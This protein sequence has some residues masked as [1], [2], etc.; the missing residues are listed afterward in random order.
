MSR[1][2]S[3]WTNVFPFV[4]FRCS[5]AANSHFV[6]TVQIIHI[7][8]PTENK[9]NRNENEKNGNNSAEKTANERLNNMVYVKRMAP[10]NDEI[11]REKRRHII[12]YLILLSCVVIVAFRDPK[13]YAF[14]L[15]RSNF[16]LSLFFSV[17]R[18]F[19]LHVGIKSLSENG[20]KRTQLHL[21]FYIKCGWSYSDW[22]SLIE[23]YNQLAMESSRWKF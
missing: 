19:A 8:A 2:H 15:S 16:F 4:Q 23:S 10:K 7:I 6:Y 13:P 14:F 22:W 21:S 9:N 20:E 17:L 5:K 12:Y 11:P 3:V 18:F 1:I